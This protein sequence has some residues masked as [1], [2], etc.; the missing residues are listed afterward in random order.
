MSVTLTYGNAP[1]PRS[2]AGLGAQVRSDTQREL[3]AIENEMWA[4]AGE[5][6][7]GILYL[8]PAWRGTGST[9]QTSG[10]TA[11]GLQNYCP[12]FEVRIVDQDA[13]AELFIAAYT[14]NLE[15]EIEVYDQ[16][17]AFVTSGL[18]NTAAAVGWHNQTF[19]L[20]S[21]PGT[22]LIIIYGSIDTHDSTG[23]LYQLAAKVRP[24]SS[25]KLPNQ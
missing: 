19:T 20:P 25:A 21:A 14:R 7:D 11:Y 13:G 4:Y 23:E 22:Y 6:L 24:S 5:P 15:V 18:I 8:G 2:D 10:Q 3:I 16:N 12:M 17:Y 1:P 9:Q